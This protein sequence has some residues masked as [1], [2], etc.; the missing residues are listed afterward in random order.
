MIPWAC[1]N[2]SWR[3]ENASEALRMSRTL[4]ERD[5]GW[6]EEVKRGLGNRLQNE[7]MNEMKENGLFQNGRKFSV[8]QM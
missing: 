2:S 4:R 5:E 1:A 3:K 6:R 7:H 8:T